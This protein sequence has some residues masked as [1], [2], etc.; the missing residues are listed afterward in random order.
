VLIKYL[1]GDL[2]QRDTRVETFEKGACSLRTFDNEGI[3]AAA[4]S[5]TGRAALAVPRRPAGWVSGK[6]TKG[7]ANASLGQHVQAL[8]GRISVNAIS[9]G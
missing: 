8:V 7:C 4:I 3:D 5:I 2:L 9:G 1:Q 6:R